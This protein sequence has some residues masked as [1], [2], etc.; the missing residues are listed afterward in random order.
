[1][2]IVYSKLNGNQKK[3]YNNFDG[4]AN[5]IIGGLENVLMDYEED[6]PE[7]IQAKECLKNHDELVSLIYFE[8]THNY[9]CEGL[10]APADQYRSEIRSTRF[11]SKK[12]LTE[13]AEYIVTKNG[14]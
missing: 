8:G 13:L 1:M 7:Y 5:D 10:C 9:Y 4:A 14:Y 12:W 2:D 11:C 6:S 3:A